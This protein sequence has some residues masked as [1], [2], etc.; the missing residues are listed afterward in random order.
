[1]GNKIRTVFL[2]FGR[3]GTHYAKL[4][5]DLDEFEVTAAADVNPAFYDFHSEKF[6]DVKF[7]EDWRALLEREEYDLVSVCAPDVF[8]EEMA[9]EV[10]ERGKHLMLEK[11]M[12]LTPEGCLRILE[13]H[14]RAGTKLF[15]CF[16]LRYHNMYKKARQLVLDGAIGTPKAVWVQHSVTLN[17]FHNWMSDRAMSGGLLLQKGSHDIDI[18]NWVIDG[19]PT[20]VSAFAGLDHFGGDAEHDL[21]CPECEKKDTC[22]D[23]WFKKNKGVLEYGFKDAPMVRDLVRCA[24]RKEIDVCDNHVVNIQYENGVKASYNECHFTPID[25]RYFTFIGDE[26]QISTDSLDDT[27]TLIRRHSGKRE[28]FDIEEGA[29]GHGGGDAG[30]IDDLRKCLVEGGEPVADEKAG[31]LSI[32]AA[33]GGERS[34]AGGSIIDLSDHVKRFREIT[35]N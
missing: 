6:K 21:I 33:E 3:R 13:D 35:G 14:K 19:V 1:M 5:Q 9:V 26:G 34:V 4:I 16:V 32:L 30:L 20:K 10:L 17:Y 8:H 15:I 25:R 7:Y 31:F 12:A 27:T 22:P 24:Y 18:I 2:G 29:G 28:I 11:P 23:S